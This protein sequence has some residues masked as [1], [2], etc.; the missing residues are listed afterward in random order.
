MNKRVTPFVFILML[1]TTA[2]VSCDPADEFKEEITT[3]DSCLTLVN[4]L[5][6][7]F[8]GIDFDSL[9]LMV[10]HVEKNEDIIR[11]YYQPDTVNE[12][13]GRQMSDAKSV[14]KSL[15]HVST[16][17]MVYGDELNAV[18]N[19]LEDLKD[20]VLNGVLTEEQVAE[21]LNVEMTALDK[22]HVS[23][24]AFYEMQKLEKQRYYA[25]MPGID[26]F[27]ERLLEENEELD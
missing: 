21:Y 12:T 17:Q 11:Q 2:L 16:D 9:N 6:A 10:E 25:V 23:F 20:D 7:K 15:K 27:V 14:R 5:E 19:Q 22:V 4:E 8:D 24:D 26:L 18:K 3:I 13:L 1:L